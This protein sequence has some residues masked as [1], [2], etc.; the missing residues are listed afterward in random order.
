[1]GVCG[2]TDG[3]REAEDCEGSL[4]FLFSIL[5]LTISSIICFNLVIAGRKWYN[6]DNTM[7]EIAENLPELLETNNGGGYGRNNNGGAGRN[8]YNNNRNGYGNNRNGYGNK[9]GYN[10]NN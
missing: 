1:M 4:V 5:K 3:I 9:N 8:G 2:V 6:N 10:N 7:L